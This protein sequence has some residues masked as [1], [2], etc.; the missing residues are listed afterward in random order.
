MEMKQSV[1][2][3]EADGAPLE[4]AAA[5][6]ERIRYYSSDRLRGQL[7]VYEET[8][9]EKNIVRR[10]K[11]RKVT[12]QAKKTRG[13]EVFESSIFSTFYFLLRAVNTGL[14]IVGDI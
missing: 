3:P 5:L 12:Y 9:R 1:W 10:K 11:V 7:P 8:C 2:R 6:L 14:N 13:W 4:V